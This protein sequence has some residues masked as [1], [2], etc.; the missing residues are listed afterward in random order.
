[1]FVVRQ[2]YTIKDQVR[3]FDVLHK[4]HKIQSP[5]IIFNGVEYKKKYGYGYG[6]GY[7]YG[8]SYGQGYGSTGE[9]N[10]KKKKGSLSKYFTK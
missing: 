4:D 8:Y 9:E 10:K 6:T 5:A 1:M 2:G 3:M 7:G